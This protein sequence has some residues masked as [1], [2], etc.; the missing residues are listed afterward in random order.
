MWGDS[1]QGWGADEE[2]AGA[3]SHD[4]ATIQALSGISYVFFL[5]N[6]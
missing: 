4:C 1:I 2:H 3:G 6:L 5:I